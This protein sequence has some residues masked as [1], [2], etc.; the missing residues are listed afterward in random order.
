MRKWIDQETFD[1]L[2]LT[3]ADYRLERDVAE[4]TILLKE[5]REFIPQAGLFYEVTHDQTEHTNRYEEVRTGFQRNGILFFILQNHYSKYYLSCDCS[6][7]LYVDHYSHQKAFNQSQKPNY[8]GVFTKKKIED[9]VAY[10]TQ[11]Y[12]N[13]ER[14]DVQNRETVT[15]FRQRLEAMPDVV[16]GYN[17]NAGHIERGGLTYT[18]EIQKTGYT[19]RVELNYR[20]RS[21]DDFLAVSDNKFM[22]ET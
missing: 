21:L 19:E 17:G 15:T 8:I 5:V 14:I 22:H 1:E 3:N 6:A 7:F 13:L 12:R 20:V 16:W 18:F 9:W 10:L 11:G 4:E 2:I